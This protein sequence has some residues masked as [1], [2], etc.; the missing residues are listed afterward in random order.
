MLRWGGVQGKDQPRGPPGQQ[1]NY[2][3]QQ[4]LGGAIGK[5]ASRLDGDVVALGPPTELD[6]FVPGGDSLPAAVQDGP[7][8]GGQ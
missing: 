1:T 2:L 8:E 4:A 3:D 6:G 7:D 5:F